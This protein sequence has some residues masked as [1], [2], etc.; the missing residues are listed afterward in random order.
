[1]RDYIEQGQRP[2]DFSPLPP[3][4]RSLWEVT[5]HRMWVLSP[6]DKGCVPLFSFTSPQSYLYS[7]LTLAFTLSLW[8]APYGQ[9]QS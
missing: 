4:T 2:S 6:T 3:T 7:D 5:C 9:R 1:M 8:Q